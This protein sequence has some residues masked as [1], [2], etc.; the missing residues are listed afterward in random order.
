MFAGAPVAPS[1][2]QNFFDVLAMGGQEDIASP[3]LEDRLAA[4]DWPG[5]ELAAQH[6]NFLHHLLK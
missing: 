3:A 5:P 4:G 6:L 2:R 1:N